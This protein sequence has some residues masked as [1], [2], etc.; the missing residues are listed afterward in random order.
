MQ[1]LGDLM[2]QAQQ[3]QANMQKM[4][5]DLAKAEV[6]GEAGAGLVSVVMNGRHDVKRVHIDDSLMTEDK[7]ML[8]D[9]LAAAVNDAVRKVETQSREQMA[10][11]TAGMG[12]PPDF[13]MPF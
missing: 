6:K 7:E 2:K 13:K 8:E 10:K 4:Q 9:L 11:M 1:G 3:M 5:E 12:I